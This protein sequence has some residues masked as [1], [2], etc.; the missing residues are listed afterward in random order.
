MPKD[1]S[2]RSTTPDLRLARPRTLPMVAPSILSADFA[3]MGKDARDAIDA[4]ADLLHVDIMDGH[5]APNLTMGPDTVRG[6]ARACPDALLDVH[7]M[8]ERPDAFIGPFAEAGAHHLTVHAEVAGVGGCPGLGELRGMVRDAG[9]TFG[10]AINPDTPADALDPVLDDADL[11]LVMSV[12]PGFSGQA[13]MP[14]VLPKVRGIARRL[15]PEQRLEMDG[16]IGPRTARAVID[17]GCDVMVAGSAL[18]GIARGGWAER[19]EAI[20]RPAPGA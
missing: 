20:R 9:C 16:G 12:V 19:I 18:F 3:N 1:P 14:E 17:A 13:F 15:R 5:F 11:V 8:V 2:M 10:V 4:G 7:L 6:L